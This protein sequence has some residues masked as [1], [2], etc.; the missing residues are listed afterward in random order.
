[1]AGTDISHWFDEKTLE[2]RTYIDHITMCRVPYTPS[3]RFIHIPP[4]F[5]TSDWSNDFDV[6]WW[7][8]KSYVIGKVTKKTRIV[9]IVN[10]LVG[11]EDEI[12]VSRIPNLR[13][14]IVNGIL[15]KINVQLDLNFEKS[16]RLFKIL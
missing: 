3:G 12:E 1:M 14:S 9:R 13:V 2:P 5:P 4:P 15:I 8:D 10:T 16:C 6:P 7:K 11:L